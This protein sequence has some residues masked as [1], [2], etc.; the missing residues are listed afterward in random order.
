MT[1]E[2]THITSHHKIIA[3][4]ISSHQNI[5]ESITTLKNILPLLKLKKIQANP[6]EALQTM[7]KLDEILNKKGTKEISRRSKINKIAKAISRILEAT[8]T[9]DSS[10]HDRDAVNDLKSKTLQ[11]LNKTENKYYTLLN[12]KK[13]EH[14]LLLKKLNA[15]CNEA[16]ISKAQHTA[17][18]T[19]KIRIE[20]AYREGS[21]DLNLATLNL[22]SL[23]TGVFKFLPKLTGLDLRDNQITTLPAKAFMDLS[24]L[25]TLDLS[26]NNLTTIATGTFTGLSALISLNLS[27]NELKTLPKGAFQNLSSLATL[28]LTVN[29]L[30]TLVPG[31]FTGLHSLTSL[32][33]GANKLTL[34]QPEVFGGLSA[35]TSLF[36]TWN[37]IEPEPITADAIRSYN[38]IRM[39]NRWKNLPLT[40]PLHPLWTTPEFSEGTPFLNFLSRLEVDFLLPVGPDNVRLGFRPGEFILLPEKRDRLRQDI[41]RLLNQMETAHNGPLGPQDP[42][43]QECIYVA[44]MATDTCIDKVQVGYILLHLKS[45]LHACTDLETDKKTT[46]VNL[47]AQVNKVIDFVGNVDDARLLFNATSAKFVSFVA[48]QQAEDSNL[49][50]N[51]HQKLCALDYAEGQK[52]ERLIIVKLLDPVEDMV[53]LLWKLLAMESERDFQLPQRF[54]MC[55]T[56][57]NDDALRRAA[58][59]FIAK[60]DTAP[61][62]Q[63]GSEA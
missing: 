34:L 10:V 58:L 16:G 20:S 50:I 54:E 42:F 26:V 1:L 45:A 12:K 30:T 21:T 8:P 24:A 55:C 61:H 48:T 5:L 33:L 60:Q 18:S 15:W 41:A 38:A 47:I 59:E 49:T 31:T 46:L 14:T 28:N 36:T 4:N 29:N 35:L 63:A 3:I 52:N 17:R 25:V 57:G 27:F 7:K 22:T 13:I 2:T 11:I 51:D 62:S 43:I 6:I 37:S 19:A 56:I 44:S 23:P 9:S 32:N 39:A 40:T 53:N